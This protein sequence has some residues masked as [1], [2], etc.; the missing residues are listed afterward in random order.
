MATVGFKRAAAHACGC[1]RSLTVLITL[2]NSIYTPGVPKL[3]WFKPPLTLKIVHA[4][5]PST[6]LGN[7]VTDCKK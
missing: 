1:S 6:V 5:P 4:P 3:F 2:Q 7:Q